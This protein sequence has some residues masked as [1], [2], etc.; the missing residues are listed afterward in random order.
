MTTDTVA[1]TPAVLH[2]ALVTAAGPQRA[3][4]P[5]ALRGLL[6]GVDPA[7]VAEVLGRV[8]AEGVA[9]PPAA[10]AAFGLHGGSGAPAT[11]EPPSHTQG[12][13]RV[14][15]EP[16]PEPRRWPHFTLELSQDS[17]LDLSALTVGALGPGVL[18]ASEPP[19]RAEKPHET[20]VDPATAPPAQPAPSPRP[21]PG[22]DAPQE[23]APPRQAAFD[24][25]KHYRKEIGRFPLLSRQQEAELAIAIEAGVLA[26]DKLDESGRKLA[27]KLRRELQEITRRGERAFTEFAETNLRLV[28][29][30]AA[31][32][33]GRGLDLMDLV[34]EGNLGMVH[35]IEMFDHRRGSKFST[36]AVPWIRQAVTRAIADQSRTIRLPVYA[37][38]AV[39]A[40]HR[41]ARDLTLDSPHDD[42]PAVAARVGT[43]AGEARALLSRVRTTVPLEALAE[44]IGDDMLHEEFDRTTRGVQSLDDEPDYLGLAPDE[45]LLLLGHLS[46]REA[47]VLAL[48]HGVVDGGPGLTLDAIGREL[49]VTR[50]RVRQIEKQAT[51]VLRDLVFAYRMSRSAGLR[52]FTSER[53]RV[54]SYG[55]IRV[56][57][58]A[59]GVGQS[60]RGETVV[61][62]VEQELFR[63]FHNGRQLT[64][65][66]RQRIAD[67]GETGG[68]E[69]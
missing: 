65:A 11:P 51:G 36:Y 50:E 59:I 35:A 1:G 61:V 40:L 52:A 46:P 42:L 60:L 2:E 14:P 16:K 27:P 13:L 64:T 32:Y 9:L 5:V 55:H 41:A 37:H 44:A 19:L 45:V 25:L 15:A 21:E 62:L 23:H 17:G 29:S 66:P 38:D 39:A 18:A 47:R 6:V 28:M 63:V 20:P 49:G 26:R 48:R 31:K 3:L 57:G 33:T 30:I 8:M 7:V 34:Q 54:G 67:G 12:E 69:D 24:S 43:E 10:V 53:H 56:E 22:A 58:R 4:T 68:A